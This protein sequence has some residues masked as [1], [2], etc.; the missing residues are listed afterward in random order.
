MYYYDI[1]L[2]DIKKK[3]PLMEPGSRSIKRTSNGSAELL[4]V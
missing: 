3:K 4:A 1:T 2:L